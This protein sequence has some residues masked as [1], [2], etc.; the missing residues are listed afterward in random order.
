MGRGIGLVISIF[1]FLVA[2]AV[3]FQV[4]VS[5]AANVGGQ[6]ATGAPYWVGHPFG[7]GIG[8]GIGLLFPILFTAL[9]VGLISAFR[10]GSRWRGGSWIDHR[11]T[12]LE[13][14]HRQAHASGPQRPSDMGRPSA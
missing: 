5:T 10:G 9:I 2:V 4:G 7:L 1:I 8:L 6:A 11:R 3:A 13:E 14:W 12:M